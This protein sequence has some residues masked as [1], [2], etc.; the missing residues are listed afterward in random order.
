M[1]SSTNLLRNSALTLGVVIGLMICSKSVYSLKLICARSTWPAISARI[2]ALNN[3][4]VFTSSAQ[5]LRASI[6]VVAFSVSNREYRVSPKLPPR[7]TRSQVH[8]LN[9]LELCKEVN[10]R[11]D[12]KN[13]NNVIL[14]E[15]SM[16]IIWI[17]IILGAVI[18]LWSLALILCKIKAS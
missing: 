14:I 10:I 3:A 12:P 1:N 2:I 7:L 8:Y 5:L 9:S 13:P 17:E 18:A 6:P 11:C 15:G 4:N 16:R